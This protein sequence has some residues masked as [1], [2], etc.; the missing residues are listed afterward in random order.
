MPCIPT[1]LTA[2]HLALLLA[3]PLASCTEQGEPSGMYALDG[4]I[5]TSEIV[6]LAG[7]P[8]GQPRSITGEED[9]HPTLSCT[10]GVRVGGTR[11]HDDAVTVTAIRYRDSKDAADSYRRWHD[12][13]TSVAAGIQDLD[14][15]STAAAAY[16]LVGD[17]Q[18]TMHDD[19][20]LV[21]ANWPDHE[22]GG[23]PDVVT[24]LRKT[25][26]AIFGALRRLGLPSPQARQD[27]GTTS[28]P[29]L[30]P[31]SGARE[32]ELVKDLCAVLDLSAVSTVRPTSVRPST[33]K[34]TRMRGA[35]CTV[36]YPG[37]GG[38]ES[39]LLI[40]AGIPAD[41]D[42]AT[43]IARLYAL[44]RHGR[45]RHA[46]DVAGL[47]AA[48][49]METPSPAMTRLVAYD[50]NLR[51]ELLWLGTGSGGHQELQQ[52]LIAV[53]DSAVRQL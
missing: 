38:R 13:D 40:S 42:G 29:V 53:A 33:P 11:G 36:I 3:L 5:C 46:R 9:G 20:L 39:Q 47:A 43:K 1:R 41:G 8:A 27:D 14:G 4:D 28:D 50:G 52:R 17:H 48:T 37:T 31:P 2:A 19:N 49:F 24:R 12:S 10:F 7:V 34:P 32:H 51:V 6:A 45:A 16:R 35:T 21:R 18:V 22:A 30:S 25:A 15:I 23:P 26:E 44:E